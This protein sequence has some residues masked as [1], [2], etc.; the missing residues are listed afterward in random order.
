MKAWFA[1]LALPLIG[2]AFVVKAEDFRLN[3]ALAHDAMSGDAEGVAYLDA[4]SA[5]HGICSMLAG[6][7]ME[8]QRNF[9]AAH[10]YY[11]RAL[12]QGVPE[13]ALALQAMELKRVRPLESYAW[14]QLSLVI[15]D[16]E[17][18]EEKK[19]LKESVQY[20]MIVQ[21]SE[22]L[23]EEQLAEADRLAE[24]R[25]ARWKPVVAELVARRKKSREELVINKKVPPEYPVEFLHARRA[26]FAA[27]Y[28]IFDS[29]GRVVDAI[30]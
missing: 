29:E 1:W 25:I 14:G 11:L 17:G 22:L 30:A 27:V 16:P 18:K 2:M 4:C 6:R 23:N 26:G 13:A 7:A 5:E 12:E 24:E 8:R 10:G 28:A 15:D 9:D 3:F 19:K 21:A 20:L